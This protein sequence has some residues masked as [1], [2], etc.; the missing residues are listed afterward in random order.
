[1]SNVRSFSTPSKLY[2]EVVKTAKALGTNP[3][4]AHN[5]GFQLWLRRARRKIERYQKSEANK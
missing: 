4:H 3:N 2:R 5:E 1:M